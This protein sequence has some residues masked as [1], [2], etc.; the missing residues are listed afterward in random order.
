MTS[1]SGSQ[2]QTLLGNIINILYFFF[3]HG[4]FCNC[5]SSPLVSIQW[6]K[7]ESKV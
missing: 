3:D 7:D 4:V 2:I 5:Q 6:A 1:V